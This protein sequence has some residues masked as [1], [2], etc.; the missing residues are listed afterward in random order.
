MLKILYILLF[1]TVVPNSYC[2]GDTTN[3]IIKKKVSELTNGK[4]SEYEKGRIIFNWIVDNIEYDWLK[5]QAYLRDSSKYEVRNNEFVFKQKKGICIEIS[6]LATEMFRYAGLN[7]FTIGGYAKYEEES[8]IDESK[9][10]QHA[11]NAV[12]V[13]DQ[14]HLI[15][16]TWSALQKKSI[17]TDSAFLSISPSQFIFTHFPDEARWTLLDSPIS[18]EV[19]RQYP[20]VRN[21]FFH[22]LR[23]LPPIKGII[24]M[25]S[26]A[27]CLKGIIE[28]CIYDQGVEIEIEDID[29]QTVDFSSRVEAKDIHQIVDFFTGKVNKR[30]F[31]RIFVNIPVEK[32]IFVLEPLITFL[33]I[34]GK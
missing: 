22:Y 34:S 23:R 18:F 26:E 28:K 17:N 32:D 10:L 16:V 7:C 20:I 9:I 29:E 24:E 27:N 6:N 30:F 13:N 5:Y 11:W 1:S 19:F 21:E 8:L 31:L 12:R 4:K 14:W 15:D 3:L 25:N 2:L 33:V